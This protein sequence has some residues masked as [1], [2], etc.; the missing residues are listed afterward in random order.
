MATSA[1]CL[2]ENCG[3]AV[4]GRGMCPMHLW[5]EKHHGSPHNLKIKQPL[6]DFCSADDCQSPPLRGRKGMCNRHYQ[7]LVRRGTTVAKIAR[8]GDP[9]RWLEDHV[10]YDGKDCLTWPYAR[11]PDGTAAINS[12]YSRQ[13]S[14]L[15][16]ILAHGEP[17]FANL[18]AAHSCGKGHEGCVNPTHLRWA[19]PKA[20][21]L[22]KRRHGTVVRGQEHPCATLS[23]LDVRAIRFL[24]NRFS[25]PEIATLF[26]IHVWTIKDIVHRNT[27]AWLDQAP[28]GGCYGANAVAN[29]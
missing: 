2:I 7:M 1:I 24:S 29:G 13:A 16:C 4:K 26:R 22:D 21:S 19:T 3:K 25:L 8:Q 15:M 20:N 10:N 11:R 17:E 23:E 12:R 14:R 28:E 9:R 27:W 5:R 6:A 18:Q